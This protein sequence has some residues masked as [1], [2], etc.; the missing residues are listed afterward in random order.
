MMIKKINKSTLFLLGLGLIVSGSYAPDLSEVASSS[1][2]AGTSPNQLDIVVTAVLDNAARLRDANQQIL[3]L[4]RSSNQRADE[5]IQGNF[6]AARD[7]VRRLTGENTRDIRFAVGATYLIL[8]GINY[9]SGNGLIGSYPEE[10]MGSTVLSQAS[11]GLFSY[12]L[13]RAGLCISR[14][15]CGTYTDTDMPDEEAIIFGAGRLTIS[16]INPGN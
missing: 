12:A 9:S 8:N 4:A 2:I 6:E 14:A 15:R 11:I 3:E 16:R 13:V 7:D 5:A 10:S 1:A